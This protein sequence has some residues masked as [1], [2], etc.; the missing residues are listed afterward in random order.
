MVM[1]RIGYGREITYATSQTKKPLCIP[2]LEETNRPNFATLPI[3]CILLACRVHK[4][5]MSHKLRP[6]RI[7]I[8]S[9]EQNALIGLHVRKIDP[10]VLV[11]IPHDIVLAGA[12]PVSQV[13]L[14]EILGWGAG[15]VAHGQRV[16]FDFVEG[17]PDVDEGHATS[18]KIV[19][20]VGQELF[21]AERGGLGGVIAVN[22]SN[23]SALSGV[24]FLSK[25]LVGISAGTNGM[26][27][28]Q[29]ARG[30]EFLLQKRHDLRVEI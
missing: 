28:N 4:R 30:A 21:D 9:L 24:S 19:C 23:R 18:E 25:F 29:D 10:L 22:E 3:R 14:E 6:R 16:L 1:P 17:F 27:E 15:H 2:D 20:F 7:G 8:I 11:A 13:Q 5:R 26:I 12:I